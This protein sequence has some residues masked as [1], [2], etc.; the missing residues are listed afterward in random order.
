MENIIYLMLND[1]MFWKIAAVI[2]EPIAGNMGII[3]PE[4]GFLESLRN[5]TDKY[6]ALLI[7]DEVITGFRVDYSGAQKI[8]NIIP[9]LTCLGKIIGGGLPVGAFGGRFEIMKNMAPLGTVYQAG[10]LSGNPVV[11]SAGIATLNLLKNSS[12]YKDLENLS[13]YLETL[14]LELGNGMNLQ[15]PRCGS[16]F[17]LFFSSKGIRNWNDVLSS[18]LSIYK[19][20]HHLMLNKG[21]YLPPSPYESMFISSSHTKE[22]ITSFVHTACEAIQ[23][24]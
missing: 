21:Y 12:V 6:D 23:S 10:T 18:Q 19:K 14:F 1:S 7:F 9:D 15:V 16:M 2:I 4:K 3:L 20:F 24:L 22:D 11:M 8:Y 13:N 17:G 5:I